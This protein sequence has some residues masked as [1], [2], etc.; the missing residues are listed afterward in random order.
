MLAVVVSNVEV[1]SEFQFERRM[2]GSNPEQ[3]R[4][5]AAWLLP[6][7]PGCAA[8]RDSQ[9]RRTQRLRE[10]FHRDDIVLPVHEQFHKRGDITALCGSRELTASFS[11]DPIW[12]YLKTKG[13]S[14]ISLTANSKMCINLLGP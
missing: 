11:V 14:E 2:F 8:R 6:R 13:Y 10:V 9:T 5:L 3:L 1:E 12:D 7:P 4:S